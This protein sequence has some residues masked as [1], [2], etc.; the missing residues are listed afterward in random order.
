M[1]AKVLGRRL[2]NVLVGAEV[3]VN[4]RLRREFLP[5]VVET[6]SIETSSVCNLK[7]RFCAYEKKQSPRVTMDDALFAS[8]VEQALALGYKDFELTPCTGD[9]FMDRGLLA[10]CAFMDRHPGVRAYHF[11]TNLT[12]P[13]ASTL[14]RVLALR[15]LSGLTVSLYGHDEASFV[16]IAG[17]RPRLYRRL[18]ANLEWLIA[19]Q[20][21]WPFRLALA[22]R[23]TTDAPRR[24]TT[25]LLALVDR[26][27]AAGVTLDRSD[28]VYSNWGGRVTQADVQGLSMH[29]LPGAE[30]R[31]SGP[32]V[33][34][35][36]SFQ[37]TA[38]GVVNGCSCR[39]AETTLR[40]GDLRTQSLRDIVGPANPQ[41]MALIA[42]Q[43]AGRFRPVCRDCDY[44]RSVYHQ[45]S[46]YRRERIATQTRAAFLARTG[47]ASPPAI[48]WARAV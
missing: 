16:A 44:Y 14:D 23:S 10:K 38:S 8:T 9:V 21:D 48:W 2:R 22:L 43:E 37:V 47:A 11:F 32:C 46:N 35:F 17:A 12:V 34:L 24:P 6:F 15:K 40:I 45:P 36:D 26:F 42:E 18:L 41:Y 27:V 29:I 39:D 33:K 3:A 7:C 31:K 25:D 5:A 28:G 1:N 4:R 19:R 20:A 30:V 13:A